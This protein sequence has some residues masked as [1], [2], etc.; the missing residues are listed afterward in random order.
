MTLIKIAGLDILI[1]YLQGKSP[2]ENFHRQAARQTPASFTK[3]RAPAC[4]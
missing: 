3:T 4:R 1:N 2:V